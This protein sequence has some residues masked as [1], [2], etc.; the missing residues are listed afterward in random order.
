MREEPCLKWINSLHRPF[1]HRPGLF[2]IASLTLSREILYEAI[3]FLIYPA[4]FLSLLLLCLS[5]RLLASR[6]RLSPLLFPGFIQPNR[7]FEGNDR[8]SLSRDNHY[9][10]T[11]FKVMSKKLRH[12]KER[13]RERNSKQFVYFINVCEAEI[14]DITTLIFIIFYHLKDHHKAFL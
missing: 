1:S 2:L 7:N 9:P 8:G 10:S 13:E 11:V 14:H 3:E 4:T 6:S 5:P 12:G